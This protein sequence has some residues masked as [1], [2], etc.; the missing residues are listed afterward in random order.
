M[1]TDNINDIFM[2]L[3]NGSMIFEIRLLAEAC[4]I[5]D[6]E[7]LQDIAENKGKI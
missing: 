7:I 6:M 3:C 5:Y 2:P 4:R 1:G